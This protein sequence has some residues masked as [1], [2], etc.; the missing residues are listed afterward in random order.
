ML[1][2]YN[3]YIVHLEGGT[4][5]I[6]IVRLLTLVA[7]LVLLADLLL[8]FGSKLVLQVERDTELCGKGK[9]RRESVKGQRG[10][11]VEK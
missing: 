6:L 7:P 3:G 5:T 9:Q 2:V 11:F 10:W 8:L 1:W 4:G